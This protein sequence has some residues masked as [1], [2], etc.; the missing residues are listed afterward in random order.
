MRIN[1][2]VRRLC[3]AAAAVAAL[4]LPVLTPTPAS[5]WWHHGPGWRGGWHAGWGPGSGCCW[6]RPIVVG[7]PAPFIYGPPRRVVGR[8]WI[9]PYWHGPYWVRGHWS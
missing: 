9:P 6:R 2:K 4:S 8:V 1:S 5:A 3:A 7:V